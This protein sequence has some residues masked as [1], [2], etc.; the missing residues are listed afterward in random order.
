M[1]N[2]FQLT[3]LEFEQQFKNCQL[4]PELFSHEAH[5]RL[6]WININKYGIEQAIESVCTQLNNYVTHLG[7]TGKFNKTL[8]VAAVKAV[9]HFILKANF[10]TFEMFISRHPRLKYHFKELMDT[11]YGINIFS[12]RAKKEYIEPD[13]LPFNI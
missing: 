12:E 2:H 8:T 6:A 4:A 1:E 7:A 9:Y 5:L 10:D 11:H 3:D 13:L